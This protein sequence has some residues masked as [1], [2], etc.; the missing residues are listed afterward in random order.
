MK[1][2]LWIIVSL[3]VI[4][5]IVVYLFLNQTIFGKLPEG[6]RLERIEGS[7]QYK[8][9]EFQNRLPSMPLASNRE[10]VR[11][12]IE[13]LSRGKIK[14]LRPVADLPFVKTD[15]KALDPND[16]LLVWFG[17]SSM[18]LQLEGK[19]I[20]FDPVLVSASPVSF[21]NKSFAGADRYTPED[22]P[23][24]DYLILT[25]DHW[26]HL[27]YYT[28][29][30]LKD[31][32]QT[33]I[34]PL[35]VGAHLEYWGFDVSKIKELDW[36]EGVQL[37]SDITLTALPAR[38]FS[39]RGLSRNK[40]L[41]ASYMLQSN[42]GNIFVSGDTGYDTHFKEIK[43]QF[44]NIKLAIMENGQ[45]NKEWQYIHM[46][47]EDVTQAIRDLNPEKVLSI[48]HSKYA[49]SKHAWYE[50]LDNIARSA[51]ENDF[52][53]LTPMMGEVVLLTDTLYTYEEWW[54][55]P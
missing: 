51:T 41:W 50:P 9:G 43:K 42:M 24:I 20:L 29:T 10:K 48:H 49:L 53:L 11:A 37:K 4:L 39:G 23:E 28:V 19:R 21:L 33:V 12:F 15:L 34:C 26:D 38:H 1:Y 22:I 44:G 3:L 47:P 36:H 40:T 16:D 5:T 18:Y 30:A 25:H 32:I 46:M 2:M 45:Y 31:R 17:H 6:K 52:R 14:D 35:G 27:D 13:F 54:R 55:K 8:N 7:P